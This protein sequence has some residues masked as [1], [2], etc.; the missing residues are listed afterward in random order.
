M[1]TVC[2]RFDDPSQG[3]NHAL[4]AGIIDAFA[5]QAATVTVAAVPFVDHGKGPEPF[6]PEQARH[7]VKAQDAGIV[8]IAQH[9]Y[10][11]VCRGRDARGNPSEFVGVA[12][13]EQRRLVAE[14]R[15][16]LSSLFSREVTGFVPPW[17]TFDVATGRV[18]VESGFQYL[19]GGWETAPDLEGAIADVP[20]TTTIAGCREA[21]SEARRYQPLSPVIVVV[22]HHYDFK[23]S[24]APRA[25]G[26]LSDL[27]QL[28]G[29]VKSLPDVE[30]API[31][32][33]VGRFSN[34]IGLRCA[35]RL[36]FIG[37]LHW[38]LRQRLP[39]SCLVPS[40]L[41]AIV[42]HQLFSLGGFTGER[43]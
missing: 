12:E 5:R 7:L 28:L 39:R 6:L 15:E 18:L 26:D 36:K 42:V 30:V 34:G 19:S 20:R 37:G 11:H 29:W 40:S 16:W 33:I 35:R 2:F 14:G 41:A 23:E 27:E 32:G 31:S 22:L 25:W 13:P 24:G 21:V 17:N 1:I 10:S 43:P 4:E 3:S 38:R 9:G 8:E